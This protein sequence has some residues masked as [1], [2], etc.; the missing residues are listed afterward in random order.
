M[1]IERH[2]QADTQT[3]RPRTADGVMLS[4]R[5]ALVAMA[6]LLFAEPQADAGDRSKD[7]PEVAAILREAQRSTV[8]LVAALDHQYFHVREGAQRLLLEKIIGHMQKEKQY[9]PERALLVPNPKHSLEQ[10]RRL[11]ALLEQVEQAENAFA[12]HIPTMFRAPDSWK[13]KGHTETI[14]K[15]LLTFQKNTGQP[16]SLQ[17]MG[18]NFRESKCATDTLD[19]KT[20]W[21]VL[22]SL[23]D[24]ERGMGVHANSDSH[25][26]HFLHPDQQSTCKHASPSGPLCA[27]RREFDN[28]PNH[29]SF[30]FS[31]EPTW[32]MKEWRI[33]KIHLRRPG[34]ER[35]EIQPRL[36]SGERTDKTDVDL[37]P[38]KAKGEVVSLD[39]EMSFTVL[40]N[41][42][43]RVKDLREEE[44]FHS[45]GCTVT[46][47][48]IEKL[49]NGTYCV[50]ADLAVSPDQRDFVIHQRFGCVIAGA[51]D[52]PQIPLDTK[53]PIG[54]MRK[55]EW[56]VEQQPTQ[57]AFSL[58]DFRPIKGKRT[59]SFKDV[60]LKTKE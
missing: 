24:T 51:E 6:G 4:R 32:H 18:K 37:P 1:T 26:S 39:I 52:L 38:A 16:L 27:F 33:E 8:G 21:E 56:I 41:K 30:S 48:G 55:Y 22:T 50:S 29:H 59:F 10:T 34:K 46:Y 7:S 2:D 58:P 9:F 60:S 15:T 5:Q 12:L 23:R 36:W 57:V 28:W 31:I 17:H 13:K 20:Y 43:H 35:E 14:E 3:P 47:K 25:G 44:R 42:M 45:D 54:F 53:N 40:R 49:P 11:S 19:G